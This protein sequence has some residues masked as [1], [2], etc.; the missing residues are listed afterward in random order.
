MEWAADGKFEDRATLG[1]VNRKMPVPQFTVKRSGKKVTIKTSDLTLTYTG[2]KEFD[3]NNLHVT[4][5]MADP[6]SKTGTK[7][8]TWHPGLDDSGNLL[9]TA[10]TLDGCDGI[11]TKDPYDKG[12]ASRDGWAIIDESVPIFNVGS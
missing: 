9:G 2:D 3:E 8:V 12:V 5:Q 1:I 6:T 7:K 4:F 10:R 11:T